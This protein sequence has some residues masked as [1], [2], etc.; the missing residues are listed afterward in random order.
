VAVLNAPRPSSAGGYDPFIPLRP[1]S[2]DGD[3]VADARTAFVDPVAPRPLSAS[4]TSRYAVAGLDVFGR[5]SS[6]ASAPHTVSAPAV[7]APGLH[8][9]A[10][11]SEV[12]PTDRAAVPYVVEIEL[13]WD[14]T[15]RTPDRVELVGVFH[16]PDAAPPPAAAIAGVQLSPGGAAGVPLVLKF[17]GATLE[18]SVASTHS[19]TV[20]MLDDAPEP[21]DPTAP[22]P[23]PEHVPVVKRYRV[24][25]TGATGNFLASGKLAYSMY[26][27]GAEAVRAGELSAWVA[28]RRALVNDPMPPAQPVLSAD[29][30][31]TAL[32]DATGRARGRLAWS[33]IA[34]ADGY[35]VWEATEAS[36]RRA[37]DPVAPDPDPA[38]TPRQ[39]ADALIAGMAAVDAGARAR[40]N[41]TFRRL[42]TS[43]LDATSLEVELPGEADTLFAY[44]VSAVNS[45]QVESTRSDGA[46][47]FA[48]PRRRRPG[49]PVLIARASASP[50]GVRLIALP[51]PGAPPAGYR[52]H[53]ARDPVLAGDP[54]T[55]GPPVIAPGA[56]WTPV[57][58]TAIDPSAPSDDGLAIVDAVVE[59]WY[60]Y[61]YRA[62]A[63]GESDP[64]NG[65]YAAA[66]EPSAVQRAQRPPSAPPFLEAA[67][68][69]GNATNRVLSFRA[70][71]PVRPTA[72]GQARIELYRVELSG[73]RATRTLLAAFDV[74]GVVEGPPL[75]VL[76]APT[77]A[78]LAAMPQIQ[79]GAPDPAGVA[80]YTI[81][82]HDVS[83]GVVVARDPLGRCTE[84]PFEVV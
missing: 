65:V 80:T 31:W 1:R 14:W 18:A 77:A 51:G 17:N 41:A 44:R 45:S 6:W 61:Y 64:A 33:A 71:L 63:L 9:V 20:V 19:A 62:I 25:L 38:A 40:V 3:P 59:S 73:A 2:V 54:G 79:R 68:F 5:W 23:P 34:H 43:T 11:V 70:D 12:A 30:R 76:P 4:A 22:P 8:S 47:F 10:F 56:P 83:R 29:L 36:L 52:V 32:P 78:D 26:A 55:M 37:I 72:L 24:R 69:P 66:S 27:H 82:M 58:V 67:G 75:A 39:R 84:L 49:Q 57:T 13:S 50:A 46:I 15:D 48:V 53:R 28:P 74:A 21:P 16:A 35:V 60:P 42:N 81:R 7:T